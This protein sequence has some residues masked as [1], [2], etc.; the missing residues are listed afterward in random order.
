MPEP[1]GVP[2]QLPEYHCQIAPGDKVPLTE[3]VE[4]AALHNDDGV[5]LA[6]VGLDGVGSTVTS[7]LTHDVMQVPISARK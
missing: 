5:A 1:T 7:V 3:R 2:S 4:L 6:E